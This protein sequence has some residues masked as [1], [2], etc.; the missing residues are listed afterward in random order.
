MDPE[1]YMVEIDECREGMPE[2]RTQM[3]SNPNQIMLL[4]SYVHVQGQSSW[5]CMD[6]IEM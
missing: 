1:M 4:D 6:F 2:M 3:M 5:I